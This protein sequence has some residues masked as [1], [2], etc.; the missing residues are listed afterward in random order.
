MKVKL[1]LYKS[2]LRQYVEINKSKSSDTLNKEFYSY[3]ERIK[4]LTQKGFKFE[5]REVQEA[6]R[7]FDFPIV[8]FNYRNMRAFFDND[9]SASSE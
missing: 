5:N 4:P 3:K 7:A 2:I 8:V 1:E 9:F 6:A